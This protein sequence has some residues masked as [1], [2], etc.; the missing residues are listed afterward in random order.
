MDQP[1]PNSPAFPVR[2]VT[3]QFANI[4][5]SMAVSKGLILVDVFIVIGAILVA[6]HLFKLSRGTLSPHVP[7]QQF[8]TGQADTSQMIPDTR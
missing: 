6:V 1:E 4:Y 3:F 5:R 8:N 7:D 2:M